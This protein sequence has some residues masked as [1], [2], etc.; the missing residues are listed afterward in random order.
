MMY[1]SI[2]LAEGAPG[3][4]S[5][6]RIVAVIFAATLQRIACA[7]F[8]L[9]TQLVPTVA[10]AGDAAPVGGDPMVEAR[11]ARLAVELRCL[12]CQNQTIADSNA[13]LAVDLRN[14][15]R[16]MIGRGATDQQILDYMTTRYGD[17]VLYRPP[18]KATTSLLWAGPGLLMVAGFGLLAL[19]LWRRNRLSPG[20]FDADDTIESESDVGTQRQ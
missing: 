5:S 18:L 10:L 19:A 1:R 6:R 20:E 3:V 7:T 13:A 4:R 15:I 11:L 17:F 8:W 12:V 9:A 2:A 16:E 14:Q